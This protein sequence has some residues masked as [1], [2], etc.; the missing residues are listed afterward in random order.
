MCCGVLSADN[1]LERSI[2]NSWEAAAKGEAKATAKLSALYLVTSDINE[3][4]ITQYVQSAADGM[5]GVEPTFYEGDFIIIAKEETIIST[6]VSKI[7]EDAGNQKKELAINALFGFSEP[8]LWPLILFNVVKGDIRNYCAE[9][10]Y[11][12][13]KIFVINTKKG[14]FTSRKKYIDE[15]IKD[16]AVVDK[17]TALKYFDF[18]DISNKEWAVYVRC[19]VNK[20]LLIPFNSFHNYIYEHK[21]RSFITLCSNLG[22]QKAKIFYQNKKQN[23]STQEY[24]IAGGVSTLS[25]IKNAMKISEL[26]KNLLDVGYDVE[27]GGSSII[28][29]SYTPW[30]AKEYSW[31]TMQDNRLSA[32]PVKKFNAYFNYNDDYSV[33]M[34]TQSSFTKQG[35]YTGLSTKNQFYNSDKFSLRFEVEFSNIER[36]LD[37][38][39][40]IE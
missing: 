16:V 31:R 20:D 23:N 40:N 32:N 2:K 13:Q 36:V 1:L 19:P 28:C 17:T 10:I 34:E 35:M 39:K 14:S 30:F 3:K 9:N 29:K 33:N 4:Q 6:A 11:S 38:V 25:E 18:V 27:F 8:V 7:V 5:A 37:T 24:Q 12:L 15:N 22:A 26:K 21:M